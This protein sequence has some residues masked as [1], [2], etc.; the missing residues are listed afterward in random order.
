MN[1]YNKRLP[2][3]L[4]E[5]LKLLTQKERTYFQCMWPKSGVLYI[6][7][8]PGIAKSAIARNIA[9]KMEFSYKDIRLAMVDETDVGLFP[10]LGEINGVKCLDHVVPK[11]AI[12]ANTKPTIIHFEEL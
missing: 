1:L 9:E 3:S 2:D 11:W 7:S 10:S 5:K 6:T 12:D 8:K 4:K